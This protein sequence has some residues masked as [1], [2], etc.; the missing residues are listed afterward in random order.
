MKY[1]T[2][3]PDAEESKSSVPVIWEFQLENSIISLI[4]WSSVKCLLS[5]RK[6]E[7]IHDFV[8]SVE[9]SK[10]LY[11]LESIEFSGG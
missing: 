7:L 5:N 10:L 3:L 9:D 6:K 1:G 11:W 2:P 8:N 4:R